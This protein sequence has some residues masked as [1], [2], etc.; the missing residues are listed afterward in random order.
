MIQAQAYR[1]PVAQRGEQGNDG[2]KTERCEGDCPCVP[3]LAVSDHDRIVLGRKLQAAESKP[4]DRRRRRALDYVAAE[5]GSSS[6]HG[7]GLHA[8]VSGSAICTL[9]LNR[10]ATGRQ[11]AERV[12]SPFSSSGPVW[13]AA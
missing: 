12:F 4:A 7:G 13:N 11:I 6:R 10:K 1:R 5:A 2:W 9:T 3:G 8:E